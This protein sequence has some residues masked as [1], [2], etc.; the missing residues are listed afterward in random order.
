MSVLSKRRYSF[1]KLVYC[2][3]I[4][5]TVTLWNKYCMENHSHVL[6]WVTL[7]THKYSYDNIC[8]NHAEKKI[9][10]GKFR[11]A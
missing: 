7:M 9:K 11:F 4:T 6:F 2:Y 5:I 10:L 3:D 8:H 1:H